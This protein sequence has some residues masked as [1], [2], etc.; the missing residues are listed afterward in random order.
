MKIFSVAFLPSD[1]FT[2]FSLASGQYARFLGVCYVQNL[3][4]T[5]AFSFW[6]SYYNNRDLLSKQLSPLS[7]LSVILGQFFVFFG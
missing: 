5:L 3:R 4:V 1:R 6:L 7:R 2:S